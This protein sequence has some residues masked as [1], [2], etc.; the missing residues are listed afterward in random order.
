MEELTKKIDF[1]E[2][3]NELDSISKTNKI[4]ILIPS[5]KQFFEIGELTAN[6]Q[7]KLLESA[8][9]N[10][11][12]KKFYIETVYNILKELSSDE[13][14]K[15]FTIF[16][17]NLILLALR[18]NVSNVIKTVDEKTNKEV[19]INVDKIIENFEKKYIHPE[20]LKINDNDLEITLYPPT[21]EEELDY[22]KT[23]HSDEK[24]VNELV[25]DKNIKELISNEFIGELS[26]YI[27][28]IKI[29][30]DVL[31]LRYIN[32]EKKVKV[33][34]KLKATI[35]KEILNHISNWKNDFEKNL[36]FKNCKIEISPKLFT[37][38]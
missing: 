21:V 31:D 15:N 8:V 29:G 11:V 24:T 35:I 37:D 38:I 10:S 5:K 4:K 18:Q 13:S 6:H 14:F 28:T 34:K 33:V 22:E 32:F 23:F 25:D 2:F 17:K 30:E 27:K 3:L 7:K 16:D 12:F 20:E 19:L 9:D 26:K 1:N 36:I